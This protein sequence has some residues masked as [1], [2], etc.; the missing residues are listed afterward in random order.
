MKKYKI[1]SNSYYKD[2]YGGNIDCYSITGYRI[3]YTD[4]HTAY[5]IAYKYNGELIKH[6]KKENWG[7]IKGWNRFI[8]KFNLKIEE[9]SKEDVFLELL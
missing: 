9:L 5:K 4:D 6:D 2:Y 1:K 3:F 7:S 8:N